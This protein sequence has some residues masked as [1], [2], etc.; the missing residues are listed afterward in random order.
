MTQEFEVRS[1]ANRV[2]LESIQEDNR[3]LTATSQNL[4]LDLKPQ[5]R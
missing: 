5:R 3:A 4:K 1:I 2:V